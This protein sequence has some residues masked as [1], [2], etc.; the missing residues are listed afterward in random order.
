[1]KI[2]VLRH[3]QSVFNKYLTSP[4]NCELTEE[5]KAQAAALDG[6][7]DIVICSPLKR[8][9]DTLSLSK[10]HYGR[11]LTTYLCREKRADICDFF[12]EEDETV[13]ETDED[14]AQ[15]IEAFKIFV[16]ANCSSYNNVL[17]VTHGDFIHALGKKQQPYPKNAEF[18]V[19]NI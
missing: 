16:K 17:V 9:C 4:K 8:T 13:K 19:I 18:Q 3:A 12:E 14:L 1:M 15:R 5:G 6:E 10:I 11:L 2:Q 7:F